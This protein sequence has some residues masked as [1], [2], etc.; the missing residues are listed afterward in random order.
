MLADSS[1]KSFGPLGKKDATPAVLVV[2][3]NVMAH[4]AMPVYSKAA[5]TV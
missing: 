3:L 2:P 4:A 5:V 1:G